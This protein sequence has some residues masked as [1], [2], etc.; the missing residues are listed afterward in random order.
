MFNFNIDRKVEVKVTKISKDSLDER[1]IKEPVPGPQPG[2]SFNISLGDLFKSGR[3][4]KQRRKAELGIW[5]YFVGDGYFVYGL[6][7]ACL[8][9]G[10]FAGFFHED[11]H[12]YAQI[13]V[14]LLIFLFWP[15]LPAA[16]L[17]F[18]AI[19]LNWNLIPLAILW[20]G[21]HYFMYSRG[22]ELVRKWRGE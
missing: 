13:A 17:V 14:P 18:S 3:E 9:A 2:W 22:E 7:Y 6:I 1:V 15:L 20:V 21:V 16:F 8:F 11:V 4:E 10:K 5:R 19:T 12:L